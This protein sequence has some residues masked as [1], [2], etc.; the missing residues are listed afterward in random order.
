[1][2]MTTAAIIT[3]AGRGLRA[4]GDVP[5]QWQLLAG[6]PVVAHA[7]AAFAGLRLVL[8]I[9]P[10]DRA[11]AETLG[12]P[13]TIVEGGATRSASV[14]NALEAL[15]GQ[16]ITKVLIHD[17]ARPLVSAA[18]IARVLAA[19]DQHQGAAPALAVTD[20]LW[21]GAEGKVT[22]TRDRTGLYRAQ[23]PQGFDFE[24]ILSAHRGFHGEAAD[25]VEV[26][27]AA[28][29]EVGIVD[30]CEDN[31]KLTYARDFARAEALLKGR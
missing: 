7:L 16:G 19:L 21:T 13:V 5:K 29:I 20:A 3:A 23:T 27:R 10:E 2:R 30:G 31:L 8:V 15:A 25:D 4:G 17:G 24:T 26:A 22:G 12:Q 18:V 28:G 6:Q 9:H 11:R 1:M 14:R